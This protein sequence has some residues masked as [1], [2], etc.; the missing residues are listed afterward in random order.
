MNHTT[1]LRE[2]RGQKFESGDA[3][4]DELGL[5]GAGEENGRTNEE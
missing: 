4:L 2:T 1:R 3:G 5:E